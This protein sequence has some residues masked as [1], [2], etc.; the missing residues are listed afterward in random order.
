MIYGGQ[1]QYNPV[2]PKQRTHRVCRYCKCGPEEFGEEV[3][4]G[5]GELFAR[6]SENQKSCSP[7]CKTVFFKAK[8][9]KRLMSIAANGGPAYYP[10]E[11]RRYRHQLMKFVGVTSWEPPK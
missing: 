2:P 1:R 3:C 9:E 6:K 8:H 10:P 5:C 7:E 11:I 4:R